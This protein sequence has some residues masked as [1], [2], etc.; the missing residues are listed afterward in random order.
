[1]YLPHRSKKLPQLY[2]VVLQKGIVPS[3]VNPQN[4]INFLDPA[5]IIEELVA[6]ELFGIGSFFRLGMLLVFLS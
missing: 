4:L 2:S 3:D 5:I 1:M 6:V